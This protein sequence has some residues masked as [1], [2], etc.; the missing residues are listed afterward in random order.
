MFSLLLSI[1]IILSFPLGGVFLSSCCRPREPSR[2]RLRWVRTSRGRAQ[3]PP[4]RTSPRR[5]HPGALCLLPTPIP[6][7]KIVWHNK[8]INKTSFNIEYYIRELI[9]ADCF[10]VFGRFWKVTL[11]N[12][13]GIARTV[14]QCVS[15]VLS[16][17]FEPPASRGVSVSDQTGRWR[18]AETRRYSDLGEDRFRSHN[19]RGNGLACVTYLLTRGRH[20][21]GVS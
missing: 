17:Y 19:H 8:F 3:N 12:Y 10:L 18:S 20:C 16:G 11:D 15:S 5:W 6:T 2:C 9:L 1:C 7:P 14:P 4:S 13:T 21:R